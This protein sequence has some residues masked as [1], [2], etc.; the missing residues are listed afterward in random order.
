MSPWGRKSLHALLLNTALLRLEQ[1]YITVLI[2]LQQMLISELLDTGPIITGR[3]KDYKFGDRLVLNCTSPK[4]YPPT[5]LKWV[6]NGKEVSY[7]S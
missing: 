4:T 2:N 7:K 1:D 6:I 3:R 5:R